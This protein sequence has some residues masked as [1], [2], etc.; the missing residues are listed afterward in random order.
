MAKNLDLQEPEYFKAHGGLGVEAVIDNQRMR[1]GKPKW[2]D[3]V[4]S[5]NG[6]RFRSN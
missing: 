6:F 3:V 1:I 5:G 2:F 4:E